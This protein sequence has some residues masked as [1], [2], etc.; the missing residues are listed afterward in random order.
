MLRGAGSGFIDQAELK[1]LGAS[2]M[3]KMG[4][5]IPRGRSFS[6]VMPQRDDEDDGTLNF[7]EFMELIIKPPWS[8]LLPAAVRDELSDRLAL[9]KQHDPAPPRASPAEKAI[10]L[11]KELF[12]EGDADASGALDPQELAKLITHL[13]E[14]F[15]KPI[16]F[17]F[18]SN[19]ELAVKKAMAR[20]DLDHNGTLDFGEFCKMLCCN[21]FRGL[22]PPKLRK[23][24]PPLVLRGGAPA[25]PRLAKPKTEVLI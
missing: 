5:N 3:K 9:K 1:V 12:T 23:E 21:P 10:Q 8:D 17:D 18:R 14:R 7:D 15:K 24:M 11:A 6:F 19:M 4:K 25:V 13:F 22:L 20:F 2:L 16:P